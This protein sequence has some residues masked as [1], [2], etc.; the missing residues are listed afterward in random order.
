LHIRTC[1]KLAKARAKNGSSFAR[2]HVAKLRIREFATL[3]R[4]CK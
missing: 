4:R 3:L 2:I 1:G